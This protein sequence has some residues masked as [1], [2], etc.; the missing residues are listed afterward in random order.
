MLDLTLA[1]A[2]R[3]ERRAVAAVKRLSCA[4]S[5]S[6]GYHLIPKT[7]WN[8]KLWKPS[9]KRPVLWPMIETHPTDCS[10]CKIAF[11]YPELSRSGCPVFWVPA[12]DLPSQEP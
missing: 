6:G 2:E 11:L 1:G 5:P 4:T 3:L 7:G 8:L 9:P 10:I 12:L